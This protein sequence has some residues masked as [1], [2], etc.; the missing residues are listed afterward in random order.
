MEKYLKLSVSRYHIRYTAEFKNILCKEYL[1]GKESKIELQR[2]YGITGHD[3][4]KI[5]LENYP[6]IEGER[7]QFP[8]KDKFKQEPTKKQLEQQIKQLK[9]QLEDAQLKEEAYRKMIE[10]A[11][12]E[13]KIN[14]KKK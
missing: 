3:R 1:E 13:L 4:L 7:N 2:K 5:W 10:I 6:Y 11:E 12:K 14:I 9:R 8:L